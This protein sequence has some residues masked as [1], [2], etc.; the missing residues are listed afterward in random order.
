MDL[1]NPFLPSSFG[2]FSS[3]L[4]DCTL[5]CYVISTI[6]KY[7]AN[8]FPFTFSFSS[9]QVQTFHLSWY[10]QDLHFGP[11][12]SVNLNFCHSLSQWKRG[13][14]PPC[15]SKGTL[16]IPR[17]AVR[18]WLDWKVIV[19][20]SEQVWSS[21]FG[22]LFMGL[23]HTTTHARGAA[24]ILICKAFPYLAPFYRFSDPTDLWS[25]WSVTL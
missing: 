2:F 22:W 17:V 12:I 16:L 14:C 5:F 13:V 23:Y 25:T 1:D 24:K 18:P 3:S 8:L 7:F 6:C 19:E 4:F 10:H 9:R 20:S 15:L 21:C 11:S